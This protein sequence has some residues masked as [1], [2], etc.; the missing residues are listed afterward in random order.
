M[1]EDNKHIPREIY[2]VIMAR[3]PVCTVDVLFF[4]KEKTK[5]LLFKRNNEPL[6]GLFYS[7]GGRLDKEESFLECAVRQTKKELGWD[8][9]PEKAVFAGVIREYYPN[10]AFNE[11]SYCAIDLFYGY[12]LD[13]ENVNMTFDD[14]HSEARWFPV[15]DQS[16]H[17]YLKDKVEQV[18]KHI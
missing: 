16:F 10:S 6:K 17:P 3:M 4:N 5:T 14:Q 2:E 8:I 12:I 13:D 7:I 1:P 18:L 11:I 9:N 15:N